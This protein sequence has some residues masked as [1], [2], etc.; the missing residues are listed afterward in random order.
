MYIETP[1][2]VYLV[3]TIDSNRLLS[4]HKNSVELL[5]TLD[6]S[7]FLTKK[8]Q[9][10][11]LRVRLYRLAVWHPI[12]RYLAEAFDAACFYCHYQRC[13]SSPVYLSDGKLVLQIAKSFK[14]LFLRFFL[15]GLHDDLRKQIHLSE[16]TDFG[17]SLPLS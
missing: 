6:L 15:R 8:K 2:T 12:T 4:E 14:K 16:Q 13:L 7:E 17:L 10:G 1:H 9:R 5:Q 11:C 3:P